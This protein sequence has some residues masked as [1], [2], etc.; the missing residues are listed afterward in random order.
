VVATGPGR[1]TT[2][3]LV[4]SRRQSHPPALVDQVRHACARV[5]AGAN[6]VRIEPDLIPLYAA[7]L[8]GLD[9]VAET[10]APD[11]TQRERRAAYWLTLD[12]VNFG[13]GWFPTLRKQPGHTGYHTVAGGLRRHF[14][15][16]GPWSAAEL[17]RVSAS[18]LAHVLDQDPEH[19][20]MG[21]FAASLRDLGRR[22][23][24]D[25]GGSFLAPVRAVGTSAAGVVET[26]AGW[27]CFA[28]SSDY[29]GATVPFL[30]RAQIAAADLHRSGAARFA[31]LHRLT[32]FADNLVP[33]VL[34]LDG[35]LTFEADL[36]ARIDRQ[37]LIAHGSPEEVEI[38]ACAVDAVEQIVAAAPVPITAA[39]VD[40]LLWQR[41]QLPR[42]KARPRHRA[43]C[44]AY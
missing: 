6:H 8:P 17:E 44:T 3:A 25:H 12:A 19:E 38:R 37:E 30:K 5:A 39:E 16:R 33:H 26:L 41:G 36:V 34:R 15:L 9:P 31:D 18:E 1:R 32:M 35:I 10:P 28:D 7:S 40:Q 22:L 24:T 21:L 42:Y 13:S 43:R 2:I 27:P 14:E 11:P 4:V 29:G 20:L 23:E